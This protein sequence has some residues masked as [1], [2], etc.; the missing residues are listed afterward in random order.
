[1]LRRPSLVV[2]L[3][4]LLILTG[5]GGGDSSPVRPAGVPSSATAAGV[6]RI[7]DGD[8]F[9]VS[10][11]GRQETV[12]MIGIDTPEVKDSRAP[13]ACYGDEAEARTTD[14]LAGQT[15]WL[16]VDTRDRDDFDRLLRYVWL[17]VGDGAMLVN[18]SLVAD[19][20]AVARRYPPDTRDAPR[21]EAAM[22]TARS[23]GAGLWSACEDLERQ[24]PVSLPTVAAGAIVPGAPV[25]W[26]GGDVDCGDFAT[27]QQAQLFYQAQ[28]GP[29]SD[30]HSLDSDGNGLACES[31]P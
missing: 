18:E 4:A 21:L 12:R 3:S 7:V 22:A 19:G 17:G 11:D 16:E 15:V 1:M 10:I 24:H 30:P 31:L 23:A 8:T 27:H 2:I 29:A 28:G 20:Y 5:C 6:V 13:A 26:T 14:L 25:G 9:V